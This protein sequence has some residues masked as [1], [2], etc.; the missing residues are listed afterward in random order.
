MS[1]KRAISIISTVAAFAL[2]FAAVMITNGHVKKA[3]K[4][5]EQ[6]AAGI[7]E[8]SALVN[9]LKD[10]RNQ[11]G[12]P[13]MLLYARNNK[14]RAVE[15]A[16][17]IRRACDYFRKVRVPSG[18]KDEI[19]KVRE[20]VPEMRSFADTF[21]GVFGEVMTEKEFESALINVARRAEQLSEPGG[22]AY[23]E[24]EFIKKLNRLKSR[25][26]F[27]WLTIDTADLRAV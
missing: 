1:R 13:Q 22:F 7:R 17:K 21:E 11:G 25:K 10:A 16:D 26:R 12:A 24:A 20:T 5:H 19:K 18:L 14:E 2:A 8:M 27:I 23:A 3:G 9:E 15:A 6:L 4:M